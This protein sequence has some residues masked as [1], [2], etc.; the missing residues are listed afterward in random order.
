MRFAYRHQQYRHAANA[1]KQTGTGELQARPWGDN[2]NDAPWVADDGEVNQDLAD[3]YE[4]DEHLIL[5]PSRVNSQPRVYNLPVRHDL[6]LHEVID[7]VRQIRATEE[8]AF[9]INLN[10]GYILR[11]RETG[12]YRYFR[13]IPQQ[14][15]L[16]HP[17]CISGS[18]DIDALERMLKKM[19]FFFSLY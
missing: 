2:P 13:P 19:D 15:L 6:Q 18:D 12:R 5:A 10:F 8:N 11:N 9:R 14:G 1:H 7:F 4:T 16:T 3:T 17:F